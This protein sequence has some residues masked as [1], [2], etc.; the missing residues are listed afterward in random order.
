[1]VSKFLRSL[2]IPT[3]SLPAGLLELRPDIKEY[4]SCLSK[5]RRKADR[6]MIFCNVKILSPLISDN[7][8]KQSELWYVLKSFARNDLSRPKTK[9]QFREVAWTGIPW[10][11]HGMIHEIIFV[12]YF[13]FAERSMALTRFLAI[14]NSYL[15][16]LLFGLFAVA[17]T[18]QL[19]LV[20]C[21][22][23]VNIQPRFVWF[24]IFYL[25]PLLYIWVFKNLEL[26]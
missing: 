16:C 18:C 12:M 3:K 7:S 13:V 25:S 15:C 23:N 9:L 21:S 26:Q 11:S 24:S 10:P 4:N 17:S 2:P 5:H 8:P 20:N 19:F 22:Q 1:M 6:A 14:L